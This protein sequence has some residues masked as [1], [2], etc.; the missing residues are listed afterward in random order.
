MLPKQFSGTTVPVLQ[1]ERGLRAVLCLYITNSSSSS[2]S[3]ASAAVLSVTPASAE[4][5]LVKSHPVYRMLC[6]KQMV[7]DGNKAAYS[8]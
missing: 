6:I 4:I 5:L 3:C 8:A 2:C 1:Q 7:A